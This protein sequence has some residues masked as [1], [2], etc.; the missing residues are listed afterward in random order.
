MEVTTRDQKPC[1][2]VKLLHTLSCRLQVTAT[3]VSS[4]SRLTSYSLSGLDLHHVWLDCWRVNGQF[5][6]LCCLCWTATAAITAPVYLRT[7]VYIKW[8]D[9][10]VLLYNLYVKQITIQT[11]IEK[12]KKVKYVQMSKRRRK[13]R[14]N[15]AILLNMNTEE[16]C[17]MSWA[18]T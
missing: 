3:A 2:W 5:Q 6:V 1:R 13:K 14:K 8:T 11:F 9:N 18:V 16:T 10:N 17:I 7:N 12:K 4:S 15:K